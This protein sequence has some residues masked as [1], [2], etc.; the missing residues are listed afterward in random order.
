MK[1]KVIQFSSY[2]L[3]FLPLTLLTGPFLPDLI[4]SIV[5]LIFLFLSI[6]D[7]EW[8]YYNNIYTKL[9]AFYTYLV[10]RSL[11]SVNIPLSLEASLFYF[12]FGLFSL[13]VYLINNNSEF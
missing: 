4:I 10:L 12:R 2:L 11:L 13:A 3:Y 8:I 7:K 6:R 9:F 1:N 5:G